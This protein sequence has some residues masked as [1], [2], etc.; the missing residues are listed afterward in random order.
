MV[1]TIMIVVR[2][3]PRFNSMIRIR[4]FVIRTM[5]ILANTAGTLAIKFRTGIGWG[6]VVMAIMIV[7]QRVLIQEKNLKPYVKYSF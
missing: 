6:R 2:S 4:I 1:V 5:I 3:V 7:V